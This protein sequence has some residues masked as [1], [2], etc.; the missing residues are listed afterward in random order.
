MLQCKKSSSKIAS[1]RHNVE[2]YLH[3]MSENHHIYQ[4]AAITDKAKK[5]LIVRRLEQIFTGKG[6]SIGSGQSQQQQELSN[7]AATVD[8]RAL[9]KLG[10]Y[11]Q[12]EGRRETLIMNQP[13]PVLEADRQ[14]AKPLGENAGVKQDLDHEI[15]QRPTRPLD[16]D[17][18]RAQLASDNIDYIRHLGFS[19]FSPPQQV[20]N[21]AADTENHGWVYLNLLSN[22]AQLHTLNVT[23]DFICKAV[24]DG[25][26][27]FEVSEDGRKVRWKRGTSLVQIIYD[28]SKEV[29][30]YSMNRDKESSSVG[31]TP[32]KRIKYTMPQ[33]STNLARFQRNDSTTTDQSRSTCTP[34]FHTESSIEDSRSGSGISSKEQQ[35]DWFKEISRPLQEESLMSTMYNTCSETVQQRRIPDNGPRQR[36]VPDNGPMVFYNQAPFCTDLSQD[37]RAEEIMMYNA[38]LYH[39]AVDFPLGIVSRSIIQDD[40]AET[41]KERPFQSHLP[42]QKNMAV[43]EQILMVHDT[44]SKPTDKKVGKAGL[45][46]FEASG[47]GGTCPADN[48]VIDVESC[49]SKSSIP[50]YRSTLPSIAHR[51]ISDDI[52]EPPASSFI[53]R[54]VS[55]V[56]QDLE[57][58]AVP[59]AGCVVI[60]SDDYSLYD[61]SDDNDD[62]MWATNLDNECIDPIAQKLAI[63]TRSIHV[64]DSSSS[65]GAKRED[66][67]Y[68]D[69]Y[70]DDVDDN[71]KDEDVSVDFL[72][73]IRRHDPMAVQALERVYDANMADRLAEEIPAGSSAATAG[74]GSG[75]ASPVSSIGG[76]EHKNRHGLVKYDEKEDKNTTKKD[77]KRKW[78]DVVAV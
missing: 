3:D 18:N 27:T 67:D 40:G 78:D 4:D 20:E 62:D 60:G 2:N 37:F 56:R 21:E 34:L 53:H 44:E 13:V 14:D 31:N 73:E 61:D 52:N 36:R 33:K 70:D 16:L 15:D 43:E 63:T 57:P 23:P 9:E 54:I 46:Y 29:K 68:Y 38:Y 32:R 7:H 17:V 41:T 19:S 1:Q 75:Y 25:S 12:P 42:Q 66:D 35:D 76:D 69:Y 39:K 51:L 48:F 72:A 26:H 71:D 65:L 49:Y 30:G 55:I 6:A 58:S 77:R 11:I 47:L 64:K 5:S 24:R 10:I 22:M 8:R 28:E 59:D 45:V 74:G 50:A